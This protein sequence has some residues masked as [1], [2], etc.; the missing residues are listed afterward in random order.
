MQMQQWGTA[1]SQE[2]SRACCS[3]D[4]PEPQD[5]KL[6]PHSIEAPTQWL[7]GLKRLQ[8]LQLSPGRGHLHNM[9]RACGAY[10]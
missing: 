6:A 9:T 10:A 1:M 5:Q 2:T 3:C 4:R 7:Q 8:E